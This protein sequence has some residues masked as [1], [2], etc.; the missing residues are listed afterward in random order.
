MQN[1]TK[2]CLCLN[3]LVSLVL[4]NMLTLHLASP[5]THCRIP[6]QSPTTSLS[7][8]DQM[9]CLSTLA[10]QTSYVQHHV[11]CR[12][13][14]PSHCG[15]MIVI[16]RFQQCTVVERSSVSRTAA[17]MTL[18]PRSKPRPRTWSP[19]PG[20]RTWHSRPRTWASGPRTPYC[21]RGASR[22]KTW[23]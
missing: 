18:T 10:F 15:P 19:R 22:P 1:S 2:S 16:Y 14:R 12:S 13:K 20:P 7:H 5:V 3:V 23:P 9:P 8:T 21:P 11:T 6:C 17:L 4:K